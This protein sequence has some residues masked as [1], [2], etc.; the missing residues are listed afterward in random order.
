MYINF[1]DWKGNGKGL[2]VGIDST[3]SGEIDTEYTAEDSE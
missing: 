3:G 2:S 1:A